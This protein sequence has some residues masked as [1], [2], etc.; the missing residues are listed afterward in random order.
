MLR[1]SIAADGPLDYPEVA[2]EEA[3]RELD[4]TEHNMERLNRT[5]RGS[6]TSYHVLRLRGD[7]SMGALRRA[8]DVMTDRHPMLR[9]CVGKNRETGALC[10]VPTRGSRP[11][12]TAEVPLVRVEVD[13][14]DDWIELVER[15]MNAGS[16]ASHRGPLFAFALLESRDESER[17]AGD[18]ILVELHHHGVADGL[19]SLALCHEV[20]EEVASPRSWPSLPDRPLETPFSLSPVR[21]DE[22]RAL[23]ER[24]AKLVSQ[25]ES[26]DT[27]L[28]ER[29]ALMQSLEEIEGELLSKRTPDGRYSETLFD[30]H[31]SMAQLSSFQRDRVLIH[32]DTDVGAGPDRYDVVK[33]GL[34]HRTVPSTVVEGVVRAARERG[35][36]MH[37]ALTA[38]VLCAYAERH[39]GLTAPLPGTF[40]LGT[41]VSLRGQFVP[42]IE[43]SDV[44]MAVDVSFTHTAV[45]PG[46]RFW[47]LA[48][49]TGADVARDVERRRTL[50]SWFRTQRRDLN[51]P[52]PGAPLVLV[53]NLGRSSMSPRYGELELREVTG[54]LA[55]HGAFQLALVFATLHGELTYSLHFEE[56]TVSRKS[57]ERFADTVAA[58]LAEVADGLDPSVG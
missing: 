28:R 57:A 23:A 50:S 7:L 4:P 58:R 31:D 1:S 45:S 10:F 36:S 16:I 15:D 52:P 8:I 22:A 18:R 53:S 37:A 56:P 20:L 39:Y 21:A 49:R 30:V 34:L 44:R 17:S 26:T 46:D 54:M 13:R 25:S 3:L 6:A 32:P 35:L 24:V 9:L 55:S 41:P 27:Q 48:S 19:S 12:G 29:D 43:R 5:A 40:A 42:P 11:D 2:P 33:T 51:T 38:A 14:L 47:S